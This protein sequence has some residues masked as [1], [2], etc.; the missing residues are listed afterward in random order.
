MATP[1]RL[2][3]DTN[4]YIIGA[5][6]THSPEAE[7][8]RWAG[9]G[10]SEPAPVEVVAS[11]ELFDQIA[12]VARRLRHKDWSGELIGRIWRYL[13]VHVVVLDPVELARLEASSRI[14]REDA[15]IYLTAHA[16][17]TDCFVSSNHELVR[18]LL[19]TVGDFECL[20]PE[21]FVTKYLR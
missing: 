4:V 7:I 17:Q 5:Q 16:G 6:D 2:F 9:W 13:R 21:Q 18:A 1:S 19:T 15:S 3:L 12:R 20:T 11:P 10:E 8:L 14:P